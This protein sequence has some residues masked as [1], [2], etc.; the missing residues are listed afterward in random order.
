MLSV[1]TRGILTIILCISHSALSIITDIAKGHPVRTAHPAKEEHPGCALPPSCILKK[2]HCCQWG[3]VSLFPFQNAPRSFR[4]N[5]TWGQRGAQERGITQT[6]SICS[7]LV[8]SGGFLTESGVTWGCLGQ[9][10]V[11][12]PSMCFLQSP[13]DLPNN[14]CHFCHLQGLSAADNHCCSHGRRVLKNPQTHLLD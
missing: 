6:P 2:S 4:F 5:E 12:K 14:W 13:S 10:F 8:S 11:S 9:I 1:C 7:G 3:G